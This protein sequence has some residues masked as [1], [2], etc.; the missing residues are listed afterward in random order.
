ML[1]TDDAGRQVGEAFEQLAARDGL[2]QHHLA[3]R[4]DAMHTEYVLCQVDAYGRNI[5]DGLS[6]SFD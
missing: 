1:P 2:L 3:M 4:I 6:F 5:H